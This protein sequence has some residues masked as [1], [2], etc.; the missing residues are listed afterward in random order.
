MPK[1]LPYFVLLFLLSVCTLPAWTQPFTL[2][3]DP[4]IKNQLEVSE[5]PA[6][7]YTLTTTGSDPWIRTVPLTQTYDPGQVYVVSFEYLAPEGLDNLEIFYGLLSAS[8]RV[9]FG[10]LR[11]ATT[12]KTFRGFMKL[13][14][15]T[16]NEA[17]DRFRFD[18]GRA[19]GQQLTV[20]N[21]ELRAPTPTEVIELTLNVN[22]K[23]QLTATPDGSGG[24]TLSSTGGDPWIATQPITA[25]YD[26]Q[27]TFVVTFDYVCP[28]GLDDMRIFFGAPWTPARMATFG[29]LPA[30]ATKTRFTGFMQIGS[31]AWSQVGK[32]RFD[33]GRIAGRSIT[34]SN[35][36]LREATNAEQKQFEPKEEIDIR[37]NVANTSANLQATQLADGSYE[38]NT[39]GNDPWIRAETVTD[40]YEIDATY[41]LSFE[42]KAVAAYN[43]LEVFYGPPISGA[44][45]L[46]GGALKAAADWTPYVL[47]PR[48][49]SDD[50]QNERRTE[51]RF[52]FGKNENVDKQIFVRNIKLRKPTA[53]EK[54][55]E[56]NSDRFVSRRI[57]TEFLTYLG[58]DFSSRVSDVTL[59]ATTVTI[60]GTTSGTGPFYLAEIEPHDYGFNQQ[61]FRHVVPLTTN[62]AG[63][64]RVEEPRFVA[65]DDRQYDRLYSRWAV[66]TASGAGTYALASAT[67]WPTDIARVA[68]NNLPEDKA[69]TIKGLD[70]LTGSTIGNFD[71]LVDLDIKS[72]K[73][74]L[75]LNGVY[76]AG[77][78]SLTHTFNGK[79]YNINE[80]FVQKLDASI[81]RCTE[82]DIKVALV[83]LLPLSITNEDLRRIFVHPDAYLG[84]YSMANVTS[85]EGVEYYTAMIDFLAERYSRPDQQYGRMDQWIIHNEVD[86]HTSWTH[87]GQKPVELY[88]QI[89]DRS[90]RLVHFTIRKHNP[91]AKVFAS[92]TKHWNSKAGSEDNFRSKDILDVLGRLT[93]KESDYEW[94]IAWHSYP[95]NLF[96][97]LVWNDAVSETP[98][99]FD[100]RQITP[101]NLEVI[102]A[103]V[104]QQSLLYNGKK[105]R[106]ILLSENGFSSNTAKNANA[107]QTTQ[108]AALAYFWKKT[109]L[110]L[111]AIENIQLHRW[112]DNPNEA[113]LEFGLWTVQPGTVDGF[114]EKKEGWFVWQAAGTADEDAILDPYKGTIGIS[115]WSEIQYTM[116]AEV[117]PHHVRMQLANCDASLSEVLVRFNGEARFVQPDGRVDFYNVASNVPQP[118]TIE[119]NGSILASEVLDVSENLVLTIDLTA[120]EQVAARGSSPTEIVVSWEGLRADATGY[121]IEVQTAGS[122]FAVLA[123]VGPEVRSYTHGDLQ[124]GERYTYRVAARLDAQTLSCY[125]ASTTATAPFVIVDYRDGDGGKTA[126]NSIRPQLQLRNISD[127]PVAVS[128]LTVR[129][130]LTA[131]NFAPLNFYC[132]YAA[133]GTGAVRGRFVALDEAREGANY[134]LEVSFASDYAIPARSHSGDIRTRLAKQNWTDFDE[135]DDYSFAPFAA[136][137]ET[138]K[139]TAYWD[140]ELIWG[141]EPSVVAE[142]A[143]RLRVLH[144]NRDQPGNSSIRPELRLLNEG[145][146]A[147]DLAKVT[148]RYWFSPEGSSALKFVTDYAVLGNAN[149]SGRFVETGSTTGGATHYLELGFAPAAGSLYAFSETGEMKLRLHKQDWSDFREDDDYSY[150]ARGSAYADNIRVTAYI[151][152]VL[153]WGQEPTLPAL[154]PTLAATPAVAAA[155]AGQLFPNPATDRVSMQWPEPIER[156]EQ[157]SLSDSR[158]ATFRLPRTAWGGDDLQI[159]LPQLPAG[160]YILRGTINGQAFAHR[161]VL[162]R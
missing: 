88:T 158:G 70:G 36:V 59:D 38:L 130:W 9:D 74:N 53:A 142:Q 66:V 96:N 83:L 14:A 117:T 123:E 113:G 129:Y 145:N 110:R 95:T 144:L 131:E 140:G 73:I 121:V 146:Q 2:Q 102:D 112:V 151:D 61:T 162:I 103:Y 134:Y 45:V 105:V 149:L 120:V 25:A 118:Y 11:R 65:L 32:L 56:A 6:G 5:D 159:R 4:S 54:T 60:E 79:T 27:R 41:I 108:A 106:T 76:S 155:E 139:I 23:N 133:L 33:F 119:K 16:W 72:M 7:T 89:Y 153:A 15:P 111:P 97:P 48:L 147:V 69:E 55:A 115:D 39:S 137:A 63:A 10:P 138:R 75:L 128:R 26:P 29:P 143:P 156:V 22:E 57:N 148:L 125:S 98:L 150:L 124:P 43:E 34:V 37:L 1:L 24:L 62:S 100:A 114:N 42:Y 154:R 93:N 47:N 52:D 160:L 19:A 51:F 67:A 107:N 31:P 157:L 136:F 8:R 109:Y 135:A 82:N 161:L 126:N 86:A 68:L 17:Y 101:R 58:T 122:S 18:F 20:R 116:P 99:N 35:F 13:E 40:L 49:V 78:S 77:P 21:L 132:D 104:R 84:L 127:S 92:F 50:F 141:E 90:M 30:A 94:N 152:G 46:N 91:T 85:A 28:S 44:Q 64:F 80:S 87:A 12:F 81:L 3:L 71:D